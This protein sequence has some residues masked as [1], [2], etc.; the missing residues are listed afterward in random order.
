LPVD[1]LQ[2]LYQ[3]F[4][5][6][7]SLPVRHELFSEQ[8]VKDDLKGHYHEKLKFRDDSQR[9][10]RSIFVCQRFTAYHIYLRFLSF[11]LVNLAAPV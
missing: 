7:G 4:D 10:Y 2:F 9:L 3:L 5:D 6:L 11:Y 1:S 8:E